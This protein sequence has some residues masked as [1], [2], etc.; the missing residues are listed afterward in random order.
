MIV[1]YRDDGTITGHVKGNYSLKRL[2]LSNKQWIES[3][4]QSL[5]DKKI[6]VDSK[7]L[8]EKKNNEA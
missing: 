8:V 2:N 6:D 3:D 1:Y 5:K 4:K 7:E